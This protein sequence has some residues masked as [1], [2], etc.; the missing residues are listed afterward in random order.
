MNSKLIKTVHIIFSL[1]TTSNAKN[2]SIF[3]FQDIIF[4]DRCKQFT[5]SIVGLIKEDL[6]FSG[7]NS[8]TSSRPSGLNQNIISHL[9]P[10]I[11]RINISLLT[12]LIT[13]MEYSNQYAEVSK[14]LASVQ[15]P[16]KD[17]LRNFTNKLDIVFHQR[18]DINQL[19]TQ[20]GLPPY[21]MR[22]I[23]S[24]DPFLAFIPKA[25]GGRGAHMHEGIEIVSAASYESLALGLTFGINWGLFL[26]PVNKYANEEIKHTIFKGFT[27]DKKMGGL[28]IT[29]PNY[30][31]DALNMQ[32]SYTENDDYYHLKG[33]KH[34]AGLTGTADYW[35]LTARRKT[36]DGDLMRDIDF[37]ISDNNKA[38]QMIEVEEYFENLGLYMI[39]YG[40]N[41]IN[42]KIPRLYRLEPET[43][44]ISM[45][46]DTLHRSRMEIPAMAMGFIKRMLDE[47]IQHCET[48]F[49]GAK[50]LFN[51][52]QVQQR[53]A[54]IQSA[55]TITSAI[56]AHSS[57][58]AGA[59][60]DLSPQG[61]KANSF[62]T[63]V[64]DLMQEAAQQLFQL[65]GAK[66]YKQSHIAGRAI[67]DSRPFQIFE[68]SNDIL[69]AQITEAVVKLMKQAK[70]INLFQF[71][72]SYALTGKSVDHLK[73][74]LNFNLD[75][76]LT[77]RKLVELGKVISR[78]VSM[79]MVINLGLKGFNPELISNSINMMKQELNNLMSS[80]SFANTTLVLADYKE[81]SHWRNFVRK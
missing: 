58:N 77:Q 16:F 42:V 66:A 1:Y 79:E 7:Y 76:Q 59:E 51:Y 22:E 27:T 64:T 47:A 14:P 28:M 52:D 75:M 72:K 81:E 37:F 31:S 48:R 53:L 12:D 41:K 55:Y 54:S 65:V 61:L 8:T 80:Y 30:G 19:E 44:G 56:C 26:Q 29:E 3:L 43:T 49:I 73:E 13:Y 20:R 34:W 78:I 32:T 39:P 70:E 25:F 9:R 57:D 24:A 63:V 67:I 68:G 33:T 15:L 46:L 71:L 60:N 11:C 23:L 5:S 45:M 6:Y 2:Q 35:L 4:T 50:S 10:G 38:G 17:F 69:Y 62:K 18:A 21:I 74:L 36:P 40:R